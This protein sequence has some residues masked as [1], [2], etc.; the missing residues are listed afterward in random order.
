M[1]RSTQRETNAERDPPHAPPAK[2][3]ASPVPRMQSK[4]LFRQVNEV[5]I[6]HEGRIY[7]LRLTQYNK[8]ILT[9]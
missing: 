7:K 4:D 2:Q 9:A 6:E 1:T 3:P 5:E 8:L